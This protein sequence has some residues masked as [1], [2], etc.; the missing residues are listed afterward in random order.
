M[1]ILLGTRKGLLT[2]EGQD[3]QWAITDHAFKGSPVSYAWYDDRTETLWAALAEGHWGAKLHRKRGGN[4]EEL[5]SP[6]FPEG[7]EIRPEKPASVDYIWAIGSGGNDRPETLHIGT[8]PGGLFTSTDDGQTFEL[9][10]ALWNHESRDKWFGGGFDEAGIHSIIVDPRDS[11]HIFLGISCAGIFESTDA[12]ASWHP[13]NKGLDA[14]FLQDPNAEVGHDPH[15][16]AGTPADPKTFWQQNHD[17]IYVSRDSCKT[18]RRVDK[19]SPYVDFGFAIVADNRDPGEAWVVPATGDDCRMAKDGALYVART[20]DSGLNWAKQ[21]EGLPQSDCYDLV[22][23][24]GL[25]KH[26]DYL[27]FAT[28]TGNLYVSAD[29]GNRWQRLFSTLP[30]AYSIQVLET[31][32]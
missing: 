14:S 5:T 24:H 25:D 23:R 12:G 4:W 6:A 31:I 8:V 13:R 7:T 2:I 18:W 22:Y 30:P 26:D 29:K 27:A 17:G 10:E 11:D 32:G 20:K 19:S 9:N 15:L 21:N 1:T 3:N 28:T 16:L